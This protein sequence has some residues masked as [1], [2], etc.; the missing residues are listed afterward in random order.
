MTIPCRRP[1]LLPETR[2]ACRQVSRRLPPR[3]TRE[4]GYRLAVTTPGAWQ[5]PKWRAFTAIAIT[6]ITI[7]FSTAFSFLAL[8]EIADDFEVTLSVV[9]WV[10]II[11]SLLIAALLLPLGGLADLLGDKRVFIIG[12]AIFGLGVLLT[13]ISPTFGTLIAARV[14]TAIGNAM[15][16]SVATGILVAIFPD[17]ERG[18]ALGAQTAA[19]AVGSA[20]APLLGGLGLE[21]LAWNTIFVLLV[22]PS[23]ISL[24]AVQT[25]IPSHPLREVD[26]NRTFDTRGSVLSALAV[27][28][29]IVTISNPLSVPWLSPAVFFGALASVTLLALFIRWELQIE[30]PLLQ[31]RLFSVRVF[32][33]AVAI[34]GFGFMASSTTIFLLPIYLLSFRQVSPVAAGAIIALAA[35]G[36]GVGAQIAGRLY[37]LIG[38]RMPTLIGLTLQIAVSVCFALSTD[39]TSLIFVGTLAGISGVGTA[40]WNVTN[41]GAMLGAM[42]AEFLGVGGAFINVTRTIGSV[43]SQA[44]AA[45]VVAGVMTSRGFDIP[46]G[47]LSSTPGAGQA[48]NGGFQL[49]YLIAAAISVALVGL[50]IRLPGID[51]D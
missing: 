14:V 28:A 10:V 30:H 9:G 2:G 51:A 47:E 6:F 4:P 35:I 5:Q 15:V 32:R 21:F 40:L 19:V 11:E 42:P 3:N 48:F 13:G 27:T 49:A 1:H 22:I 8:P 29:L 34:R 7:V 50:A 45:A 41:N 16:Q 38:P 24:L 46:L 37:D 31:L 44:L 17:E 43:L 26:E 25:L 36:L 39:T 20:S 23:V 18:L 33:T 12:V